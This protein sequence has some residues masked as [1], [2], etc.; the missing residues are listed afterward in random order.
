MSSE[1]VRTDYL[2]QLSVE[3]NGALL[4]TSID[5]PGE[6]GVDDA[7][8]MQFVHE[9]KTFPWPSG[10]TIDV[11]VNKAIQTTEIFQTRMDTDPP[12]FV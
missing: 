10:S 4:N 12:T 3:K 5:I 2:V 1:V 9:L 11:Q 8:A 6:L 7:L